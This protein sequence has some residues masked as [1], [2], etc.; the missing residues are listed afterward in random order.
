V[1]PLEDA[2]DRLVPPFADEGDDWEGKYGSNGT[3]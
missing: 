2:L 1:S 3:R